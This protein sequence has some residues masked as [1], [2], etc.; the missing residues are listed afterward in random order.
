MR[1]WFKKLGIC[2]LPLLLT[3]AWVMLISEGYL[4]FGGGDK[5]II[6]LIPWL[7]WSLLF[8]IIFGIWWARGKTAKQAIYGAA[9]G[10][11]AIVILA[12]LVLLIWSASKYGGF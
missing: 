3:P 7:I 12:W 10:A 6:L 5:D 2:L 8:A 1:S 9:G 4:N 11:A